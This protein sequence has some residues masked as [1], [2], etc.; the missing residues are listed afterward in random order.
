LANTNLI[1]PFFT[2]DQQKTE[3]M[4]IFLDVYVQDPIEKYRNVQFLLHMLKLFGYEKVMLFLTNFIYDEP[5]LF[6]K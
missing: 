6:I 4:E 5:E 1:Y 3:D 2:L